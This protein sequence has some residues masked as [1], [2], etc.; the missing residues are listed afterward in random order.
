[1]L[2]KTSQKRHC[3]ETNSSLLQQNHEWKPA[4]DNVD[5]VDVDE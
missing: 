2:K 3:L 5:R 1:M 4:E